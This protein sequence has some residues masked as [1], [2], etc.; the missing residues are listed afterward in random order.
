MI[1]CS[2]ALCALVSACSSDS[3]EPRRGAV[4][5]AE[6]HA[7]D[8]GLELIVNSCNGEPEATVQESDTEISIEV[9]STVVKSG[10]ACQDQVDITL[11][12]A[13]SGK[14][15]IDLSNNQPVPFD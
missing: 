5:I 7:T 12:S 4:A 8:T 3:D 6:A 10:A 11:D 15:L 14:T 2:L 13:S 9:I 1:A